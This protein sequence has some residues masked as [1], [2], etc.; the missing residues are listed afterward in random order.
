MTA[1][2]ASRPA[3]DAAMRRIDASVIAAS[4]PDNCWTT[5]QRVSVNL[6]PHAKRRAE[7]RRQTLVRL[8]VPGAEIPPHLVRQAVLVTFGRIDHAKT[9]DIRGTRRRAEEALDRLGKLRW[10]LDDVFEARDQKLRVHEPV[11]VGR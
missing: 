5:R 8:N 10:P 2:N 4:S 6:R 3:S 9:S 11:A 7:Q 1:S